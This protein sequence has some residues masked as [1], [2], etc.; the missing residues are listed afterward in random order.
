MKRRDMALDLEVEL[1]PELWSRIITEALETEYHTELRTECQL[2]LG[3]HCNRWCQGADAANYRVVCLQWHQMVWHC[4]RQLGAVRWDLI[5]MHMRL[6]QAVDK[7]SLVARFYAV[8]CLDFTPRPWKTTECDA[9]TDVLHQL[10][11]LVALR[12]GLDAMYH[13]GA[14][15][16]DFSLLTHL[17]SLSLHR[18]TLLGDNDIAP[19]APYLRELELSECT[20][21]TDIGLAQFTALCSLSLLNNYSNSMRLL[22]PL[23]ALTQLDLRPGVVNRKRVEQPRLLREITHLTNLTDLTLDPRIAGLPEEETTDEMRQVSPII[24][25]TYLFH[26]RPYKFPRQSIIVPMYSV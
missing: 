9:L 19:L 24:D 17:R 14:R 16:P 21:I 7:H 4:M 2:T 13:H 20:G 3:G 10:P 11:H 23:A 6:Y 12:C 8:Q 15:R 18:N 22:R 25:I 26:T 5:T 1:P